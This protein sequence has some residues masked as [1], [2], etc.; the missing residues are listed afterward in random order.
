[1]LPKSILCV[2]ICQAPLCSVMG[3]MFHGDDLLVE[4]CDAAK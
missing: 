3:V 2:W 1:M 4:V